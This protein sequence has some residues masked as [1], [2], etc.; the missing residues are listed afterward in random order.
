MSNTT[1]KGERLPMS[2]EE[3]EELAEY[4]DTHDASEEPGAEDGTW[5]EPPNMV[6][7]SIRV[8][9]NTR[10]ALDNQAKQHGMR[11]TAYI[12]QILEDATSDHPA[13]ESLEARVT[14]LEAALARLIA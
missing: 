4:Y 1:D 11:R 5:I 13:G 8:T 9:E 10:N 6:T 7:V 12:R 3:L 14:R 2:E